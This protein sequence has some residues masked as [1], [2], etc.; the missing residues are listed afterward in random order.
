MAT[1]IHIHTSVVRS[2]VAICAVYRSSKNIV[3]RRKFSEYRR[4]DTV[5]LVHALSFSNEP[6]KL[7]HSNII[8]QYLIHI[9]NC[10]LY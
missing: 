3:K 2:S 1:M 8:N 4:Y 9:Y 6:N 10:D 5:Q 7:T